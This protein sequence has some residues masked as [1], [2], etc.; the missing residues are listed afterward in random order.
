MLKKQDELISY[1][2]CCTAQPS[3][4]FPQKVKDG[5]QVALGQPCPSGQGTCMRGCHRKFV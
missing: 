2:N 5:G 4:I 1:N 3:P